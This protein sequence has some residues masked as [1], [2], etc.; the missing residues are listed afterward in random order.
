MAKDYYKILG[1][2][3]KA[4]KDEIKKAFRKLAHEHHPDKNGGDA[5]K[6][7]E[8]SEA[9]AVLSD[10]AKRSQYDTYG[11]AFQGGAGGA[12]F[13]PNDFGGFDFSGF[14]NGAGTDFDLG[15][16]FSQFFGGGGRGGSRQKKGA[17]ISIDVDLTFQESVFGT[18][19]KVKIAKTGTCDSCKG[20]GAEGNASSKT[21][22]ICGGKGQVQETRASFFGAI[23]S[24]RTC[25]TC[26][27]TG[28]I[29][30]VKC[31]TCR[32]AGVMR[33]TEEVAFRIPSGINDGE[34]IRMT[35][36]G[37]AVSGG[38]SGD[39]YIKAHVRKHPIFHKEGHNLVMNLNIKLTTALAG[40]EEVIESL[41]GPVTIR[42]PAGIGFGEIM[43]IKGK[44]VPLD[45]AHRGD[46]LA[47]VNIVIPN[48]IS[49]NAQKL[50]E[51][52]KKEGI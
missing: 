36:A 33:K 40:G 41:D 47:K 35:G 23:Q 48:K 31:R 43:R 9:Y 15:D 28:K 25:D 46:I 14:T 37:E 10:D 19:K 39:L 21:C 50:I 44:G 6:F 8:A 12:G 51:D 4:S 5:S 27:G 17:D 26:N 22:H 7:K 11:Q 2:D 30:E 13:N 42:I 45:K 3:K 29:P 52:L 18:E 32:G 20:S 1:V 16:I 38:K 24:V 49:K 34:M